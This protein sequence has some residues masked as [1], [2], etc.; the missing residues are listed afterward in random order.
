MEN[1]NRLQMDGIQ[2]EKNTKWSK[3][4]Q[5]MLKELMNFVAI[6]VILAVILV[7]VNIAFPNLKNRAFV[8]YY[9][10]NHPYVESDS[11]L[12]NAFYRQG[13]NDYY[14]LGTCGLTS[15]ANVINIITD[16]TLYTENDVVKV[17]MDNDLCVKDTFPET[18]GATQ[19]SDIVQI[20]D[21]LD[22]EGFI[23]V[24]VYNSQ[25]MLSV[26]EL[27]DLISDPKTAAIVGV[28]SVAMT[29]DDLANR[30]YKNNNSAADHRIT[31][32]DCIYDGS[33]NVTGFK[34]VDSGFGLDQ[35]SKER[36]QIMYEGDEIHSID[37][38]SII[39]LTYTK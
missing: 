6:I 22:P 4:K 36:F 24:T 34:I 25:N 20:A 8:W 26:D 9:N 14:A 39:L 13:Q 3:I 11:Y 38:E 19:T 29:A 35:V 37:E 30:T 27:A 31:V 1:N 2:N 15:I 16:S 10:L 12:P 21:I 7:I 18:M 28:D 23:Q 5:I 17:A 32:Y 33:G